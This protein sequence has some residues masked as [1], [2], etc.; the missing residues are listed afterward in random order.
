ML[1]KFIFYIL[2]VFKIVE[3]LLQKKAEDDADHE[4]RDFKK[5]HYC[6]Y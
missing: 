2:F 6:N 4:H 1:S 3:Y 5:R